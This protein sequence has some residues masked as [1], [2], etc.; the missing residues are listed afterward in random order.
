MRSL[1]FMQITD[2]RF[3]T[4]IEQTLKNRMELLNNKLSQLPGVTYRTM[5]FREVEFSDGKQYRVDY[6]INKDHQ[7]TWDKIYETVNS[8]KAVPYQFV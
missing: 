2:D 5:R 6:L 3:D 8:V 4:D 1:Y 7:T